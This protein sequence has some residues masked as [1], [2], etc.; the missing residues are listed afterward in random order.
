METKWRSN[1]EG[2]ESNPPP[3]SQNDTKFAPA[4]FDA[5]NSNLD[6]DAELIAEENTAI[7]NEPIESEILTQ[8]L[9]NDSSSLT[10]TSYLGGL[11]SVDLKKYDRLSKSYKMIQ[12][13][14]PLLGISFYNRSSEKKFVQTKNFT[15]VRN[16]W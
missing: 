16:K 14:E 1:W 7:P 12:P 13:G 9:S 4:V 5:N 6:S 15:K 11:R 8:G 2:K 3:S 10:F